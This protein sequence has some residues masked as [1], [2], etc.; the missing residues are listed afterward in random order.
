MNDDLQDILS[1]AAEG[2]SVPAV[3]VPVRRAA[4]L[5]AVAAGH[6][7]TFT[8]VG[9]AQPVPP[10]PGT[11]AENEGGQLGRRG[12]RL[13]FWLCGFHGA[14]VERREHGEALTERETSLLDLCRQDFADLRP[15][16]I[17]M[18]IKRLHTVVNSP[19]AVADATASG[20]LEAFA[21]DTVRSLSARASKLLQDQGPDLAMAVFDGNKEVVEPLAIFQAVF[22]T[23]IGVIEGFERISSN[24]ARFLPHLVSALDSELERI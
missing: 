21:L 5:H 20:G 11:Q 22:R 9:V 23:A 4:R 8:M 15:L 6:P 10:A 2:S 17:A 1:A 18:A 7:S 19:N 16:V 12:L 3:E 13:G 14:L 24:G